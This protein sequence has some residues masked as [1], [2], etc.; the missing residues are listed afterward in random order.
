MT[1]PTNPGRSESGII[2]STVNGAYI[3]C[4][5]MFD[6]I[7]FV[8]YMSIRM[9]HPPLPPPSIHSSICS[10]IHSLT[11]FFI[12]PFD[13]FGHSFLHSFIQSS[14][15]LFLFVWPIPLFVLLL[16]DFSRTCFFLFGFC[17]VHCLYS[18]SPFN[19]DFE[20][21]EHAA[22]CRER[23]RCHNSFYSFITASRGEWGVSQ[24]KCVFPRRSL[25]GWMC[26]FSHSRRE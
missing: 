14:I 6:L 19:L 21:V 24:L 1:F 8:L 23:G 12:Q 15:H 11:P 17:L 2:R 20:S 9:L 10:F 5:K 18:T 7:R 22:I 13:L 16:I 4:L 3:M 25:P 26:V